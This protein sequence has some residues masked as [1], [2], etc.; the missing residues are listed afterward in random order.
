MTWL[1]LANFLIGRRQA[2]VEIAR[3]REAVW[4]G[5]AFVLLAGVARD[6]DGED[7]LARP[8]WLAL[9]FAASLV[10][11]LLLYGLEQLVATPKPPARVVSYRQFLALYWLT[12]P[13]AWLYALPV[14]RWMSE[15][16]AAEFNL[17]LL[18]IVATWRVFLM[19]RVFSVLFGVSAGFATTVVLFFADS[20]VAVA[21]W[22]VPIPIF[23][24]MGGVRLTGSESVLLGSVL[25]TR[26]V[27]VLLWPI[28]LIVFVVSVWR[29]RQDRAAGKTATQTEPT[30]AS[31]AEAP[32][33]AT[34]TPTIADVSVP[35]T[36]V[37]LRM[38]SVLWTLPAALLLLGVGLLAWAQPEQRLRSQV[39]R[40]L[41]GNQVGEALRVLSAH[42]ASDFPPHWDPP[43]RT[44]FGETKPCPASVARLAI[45]SSAAEW[46][47]SVYVEKV[48]REFKRESNA[49]WVF[50]AAED[51]EILDYLFVL[52]RFPLSKD[53]ERD[54][55]TYAL[56]D[57]LSEE[58][59]RRI[60]DGKPREKVSAEMRQRI[61]M[62]LE[63][64]PTKR[65]PAKN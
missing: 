6:Y 7:L 26:L 24:V 23:N 27:S 20:V 44:A 1:T 31:T 5:L 65:S 55:V 12:A 28:L 3:C 59:P 46:V 40:L 45:E 17:W 53:Y 11:S 64:Q 47:V 49:R 25:L 57:V 16:V 38:S 10:T 43:P 19:V 21:S 37:P 51:A 39:E 56:R 22:Q 52:E 41:R 58:P 9:P 48:H 34:P 8:Y 33:I 29:R 18:A 62:F 2:I 54:G 36:S 13:L 14:E 4:L 42:R 61:E 32:Q 35:D 30:S 60:V 50:A 63:Q 15:G